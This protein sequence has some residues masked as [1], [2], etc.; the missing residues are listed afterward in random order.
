MPPVSVSVAYRRPQEHGP[1][2]CAARNPRAGEPLLSTPTVGVAL[3]T[4]RGCGM[5]TAD[6]R[7][8]VRQSC[9]AWNQAVHRGLNEDEAARRRF[10][11]LFEAY[12]C[13]CGQKACTSTVSLT[14]EEYDEA[15]RDTIR[16]IVAPGHSSPRDERVV[17]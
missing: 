4:S 1:A 3:R 10:S 16:Y 17:A 15:R 13:E 14:A 7:R 12:V 11:A 9:A 2:L 6:D 5:A 8:E